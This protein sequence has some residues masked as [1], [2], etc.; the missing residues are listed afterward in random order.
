MILFLS[1]VFIQEFCAINRLP[2][3]VRSCLWLLIILSPLGC[4][5]SDQPEVVD[6]S[7]QEIQTS[8]PQSSQQEPPQ[9][10]SNESPKSI[11]PM[12]VGNSWLYRVTDADGTVRRVLRTIS[13]TKMVDGE[14][15]YH[16]SV[17]DPDDQH[18]FGGYDQLIRDGAIHVAFEHD[19]VFRKIVPL[20]PKLGD[21]WESKKISYKDTYKIVSLDETVETP[22]GTFQCVAVLNEIV[23]RK[24]TSQVTFYFAPGIGVVCTHYSDG[25][26]E[27]L[28]KANIV[29]QGK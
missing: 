18:D 27:R 10:K 1:S 17:I 24:G 11:E 6:S 5:R 7:T 29:D 8:S 16:Y 25:T 13:E 28:L 19:P 9:Q 21:S 3:P 22:A 14:V 15:V 12:K 23:D 26:D 20:S 4:S 2:H